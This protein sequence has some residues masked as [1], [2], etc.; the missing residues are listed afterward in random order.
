MK[1]LIVVLAFLA[2]IG[3]AQPASDRNQKTCY[4]QAKKIAGENQATFRNHYDGHT[5]WLELTLPVGD[6]R[7]SFIT[8]GNAYE[9]QPLGVVATNDEG[10]IFPGNCTVAGKECHSVREFKELVQP[11]LTK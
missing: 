10:K 4:E 3:A 2:S 7:A 1:K 6:I 11:Y 9:E 5:C 8:F